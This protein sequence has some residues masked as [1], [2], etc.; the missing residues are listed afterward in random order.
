MLYEYSKIIHDY[1]MSKLASILWHPDREENLKDITYKS[2]V[3]K[4]DWVE[5]QHVELPNP[6]KTVNFPMW[7]VT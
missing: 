3:N 5:A 6:S 7:S 1:L 4:F 2:K